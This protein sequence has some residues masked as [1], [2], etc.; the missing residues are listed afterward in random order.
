MSAPGTRDWFFLV[1]RNSIKA[2]VPLQTTIGSF[3]IYSVHRSLIMWN[4]CR[5]LR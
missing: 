5:A 3:H 1:F 2:R 4:S